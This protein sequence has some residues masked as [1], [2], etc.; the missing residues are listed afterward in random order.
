[1]RGNLRAG[2]LVRVSFFICGVFIMD[3]DR[4]LNLYRKYAVP[5]HIIRHM[6]EVAGLQDEILE[7]IDP[8]Q[9]IYDH[10]VLRRAAL[11]HDIARLEKNHAKAGAEILIRE[12]MPAEAQLV[13]WHH[14]PQR[15]GV[16][17]G[18][19]K[20]FRTDPQA[21]QEIHTCCADEQVCGSGRLTAAD[22][23][24]YADKCVRE[25]QR[26]SVEER[27]RASAAK[28]TTPEAKRKHA[29]LYQK[30]MEIE[31]LLE[32]I[33]RGGYNETVENR[34]CGRTDAMS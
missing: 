22:I 7:K 31:R 2:F 6:R 1:M 3:E 16:T 23:L 18:A 8:Q 4:I 30:T 11:L 12:G 17:T 34:R 24:F 32:E 26:V 29:Q 9:R 25:D 33:I 5:E 14:S 13:R 27:F 21:E 19:D 15:A 20:W 28:C 10:E